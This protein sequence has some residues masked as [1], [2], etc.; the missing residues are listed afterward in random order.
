MARRST[1]RELTE[2]PQNPDAAV[3]P[4][5]HPYWVLLIA[6][7]L[8][9]VGQVINN[10]P[11]RGMMFLFFIMSLGWVTMHLSSPDAPFVAR[12]A[13]GLL[14]YAIS[15]LDAYRWA[16]YRWAF[17]HRNQEKTAAQ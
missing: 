15:I 10:T 8:P 4:P 13:G 3:K 2:K 9:G 7:A 17:F 5:L 11:N 14:I 16:R 6:V 1:A 12:Y